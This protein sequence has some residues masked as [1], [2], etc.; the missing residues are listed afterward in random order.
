MSGTVRSRAATLAHLQGLIAG[1]QKHFPK[2]SFTLGNTTLTTAALVA[3]LQGVIAA[4][5]AAD[6]AHAA[7]DNA[8]AA[9]GKAKKDAAS[10]IEALVFFIRATFGSD[11]TALADF[12]LAPPAPRR[13]LTSE[14]KAAAAAKAA[15]TRKLR[16]TLGPRQ[17]TAI[18]AGSAAG[19][20]P[21]PA[22][23]P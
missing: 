10:T 23:K 9:L 12:G 19:P 6:A 1:V 14:E 11:P 8:L 7:R 5:Q 2:S 21:P 18:R 17:R 20:P 13:K 22:A 4:Q 15:A 3:L 16:G